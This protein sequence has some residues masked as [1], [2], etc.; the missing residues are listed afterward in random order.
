LSSR[1][2][3]D[4][5]FAFQAKKSNQEQRGSTMATTIDFS[6]ERWAQ[7]R[8]TYRA[9][10]AG[11]LDRPIIHATC[12]GRDPQRPEPKLAAKGFM[13]MYD[14]ESVSPAEIVDRWDYDLSCRQFLGDAFPVVW[15]N[16]GPGVMAAFIGAEIGVGDDTVWFHP[17]AEREAAD[18]D[19]TPASES[20]PWLERVRNL[21]AVA[22]ERWQGQVQVAM[23]DLGGNLDILSTFRPA[24]QL[25]F[26]LY[27]C[28]D[29]VKRLTWEA[30]ESW[31]HY[32]A[33]LDK[34]IRETN[35]GYSTWSS[36]FSE[37]PHYMLQCDFCYMIGPD[38]FDEFVRPELAASCQKLANPFY[39]LDGPGQLA[40]LDSL[41]AIEALAGVQW[42]PGA[43]QPGCAHWPEVYRKIRG[44][45]K[46][47]QLFG[48]LADLDAVATQ[49]GSGR[50]L[51]LMCTEE[52]T[53][54]EIDQLQEKWQGK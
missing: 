48:S 15:P 50:G 47:I 27:D 13:P 7:I 19:L 33:L 36:F 14:W 52:C 1:F 32:F 4:G 12:G 37:Q 38:M 5:F 45:G 11:E 28:P 26:D 24:E 6:A 49:L 21:M 41:L 17:R 25:L 43:G 46:K 16:F 54:D 44:A 31:W 29:E 42:V 23:T 8:A 39:H 10:W 30:H 40:H 22:A 34:I 35:P 2:P 3:G 9:W 51:L 20:G 53:Q 18:L